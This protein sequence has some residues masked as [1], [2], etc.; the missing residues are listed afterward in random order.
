MIAE[1]LAQEDILP[2]AAEIDQNT[3]HITVEWLVDSPEHL[4][5]ALALH[6]L[7]RQLSMDYEWKP[8][9]SGLS[10]AL[11]PD[12][13]AAVT[14]RIA[15]ASAK[16]WMQLGASTSEGYDLE[17]PDQILRSAIIA[18]YRYFPAVD[19][20][21][22]HQSS[23]KLLK[24]AIPHLVDINKR[25]Q[26]LLLIDM[27]L[28][29]VETSSSSRE[30]AFQGT[31]Q[32]IQELGLDLAGRSYYEITSYWTAQ[33]I[34]IKNGQSIDVDEALQGARELLEKTTMWRGGLVDSVGFHQLLYSAIV[35][36]KKPVESLDLFQDTYSTA[37]KGTG[38]PFILVSRGFFPLLFPTTQ[39][40]GFAL[41]EPEAVQKMVE[42][43]RVSW[44]IDL[45]NMAIAGDDN[46]KAKGLQAF[47]T[48]VTL[49][50]A[51]QEAS[52]AYRRL[53]DSKNASVYEAATQLRRELL[54]NKINP[55]N[56]PFL[57]LIKDIF[58]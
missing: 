29:R 46:A 5:L 30:A 53:K 33:S 31:A 35:Y 20:T 36:G 37:Y 9:V 56:P 10:N 16:R 41:L 34:L 54:K 57:D 58:Y 4:N 11:S 27:L 52:S 1:A 21:Q 18:F 48:L 13:M 23:E 44:V 14:Q 2:L 15:E 39:D 45:T 6:E 43:G 22:Y 28:E 19:S 17:T 26:A 8:Y 55:D 12:Q 3:T 51:K 47:T 42:S 7:L 40:I 49:G 32:I 50:Q 25:W 38:S 24:L